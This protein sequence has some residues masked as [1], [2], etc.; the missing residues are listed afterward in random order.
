M[1]YFSR[2]SFPVWWRPQNSQLPDSFF[3]EQNLEIQVFE[4][5]VN[6]NNKSGTI[7]PKK[8]EI[9]HQHN[10]RTSAFYLTKCGWGQKI[11]SC[12]SAIERDKFDI[13][14]F[15]SNFINLG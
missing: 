8:D 15:L 10:K 6:F 5:I 2:L 9:P 14:N 1:D 4:A 7:S 11:F 3:R 13:F 12:F